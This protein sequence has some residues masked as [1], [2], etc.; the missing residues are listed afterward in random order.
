MKH[1]IALFII[2]VL[3]IPVIS[4]S[5][6]YGKKFG[7][8]RNEF[9]SQGV[10]KSQVGIELFCFY[11]QQHLSNEG[12]QINGHGCT[13]DQGMYYPD[14]FAR[15]YLS[16]SG[17]DQI[18]NELDYRIGFVIFLDEDHL[19]VS[20]CLMEKYISSPGNIRTHWSEYNE[21]IKFINKSA[22]MRMF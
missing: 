10:I 4:Y 16:A 21:L 22:K 1:I 18:S 19:F 17:P 11:L 3:I 14:G 2:L 13:V 7:T 20:L 5:E 12:Y 6:E 9:C 8:V 15:Y